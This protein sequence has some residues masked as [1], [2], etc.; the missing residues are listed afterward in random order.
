MFRNE[1]AEFI[2]KRTYS[3]WLEEE[4]RREEWPETVARFVNFLKSMLFACLIVSS[5]NVTYFIKSFS[6]S[7]SKIPC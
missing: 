3:R 1:V 4:K 7:I 2:Y 5:S 6:W